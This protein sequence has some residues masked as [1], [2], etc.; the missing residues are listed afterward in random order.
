MRTVLFMSQR[1]FSF[2]LFS[3]PFVPY[4]SSISLQQY[5][6]KHAYYDDS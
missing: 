5:P 3:Y 2:V 4:D 6:A 1:K